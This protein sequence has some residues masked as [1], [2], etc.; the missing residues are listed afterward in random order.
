MAVVSWVA[1]VCPSVIGGKPCVHMRRLTPLVTP[2]T[3]SNTYNIC[4]VLQDTSRAVIC[5]MINRY[6]S[7]SNYFL[8]TVQDLRLI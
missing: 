8:K 3:L 6:I 4:Y 2:T 7:D 5:S 1:R